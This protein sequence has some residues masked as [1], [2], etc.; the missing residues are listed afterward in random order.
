MNK[1][2]ISILTAATIIG[3]VPAM[4]AD[5]DI[6]IYYNGDYMTYDDVEPQIINDRTML[7]FRKVLET[8]G[9][10][11]TYDEE[12][13]TV[14]A[15]RGDIELSF[16]L[17][18]ASVSVTAGDSP[19]TLEMDTAPVIQD[20]R[21]LVPVRFMSEALGMRVGWDSDSRTVSI[22]DF[23]SYL[24]EIK[25]AAPT[26]YSI[27][28]TVSEQPASYSG[29]DDISISVSDSDGGSM[30]FTTSADSVKN[31][32]NQ[33]TGT[34]TLTADSFS[35]TDSIKNKLQI[36]MS[37]V[38]NVSYT[39]KKGTE[40]TFFQ[41]NLLTKLQSSSSGT[42]LLALQF[43]AGDLVWYN[44]DSDLIELIKDSG[45]SIP[46]NT[47]DA[48]DLVSDISGTEIIGIEKLRTESVNTGDVT[49]DLAQELDDA[50]ENC[51]LIESGTV[52]TSTGDNSCV[53]TVTANNLVNIPEGA[54]AAVELTVTITDGFATA[55]TET[56]AIAYNGT[57]V[58]MTNTQTHTAG[59]DSEEITAPKSSTSVTSM[60]ELAKK[61]I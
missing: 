55:D 24:D 57:N 5:E 53:Y 18:S 59:S 16:S 19:S 39:M 50:V 9:A 11:V 17:D 54:E 47:S 33:Y 37:N 21:T 60:F 31:G 12:T 1:K 61:F 51:K 38:E 2:I 44:I 32:M 14:G 13:R 40:G 58:N 23:E 15:K 56:V 48:M 7:P 25:T 36:D 10:E 6:K 46:D 49:L 45:V 30:S 52:Y 28:T 42:G 43:L 3:A 22:V 35:I 26:V 8:M 41:T 29:H 34:F 27:L 4:A 20:G